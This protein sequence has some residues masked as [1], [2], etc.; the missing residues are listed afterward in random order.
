[1]R[2]LLFSLIIVS[3]LL[4]CASSPQSDESSYTHYS[5]KI[6]TYSFYK[7]VNETPKLPCGKNIAV[8][9]AK[10]S[11]FEIITDSVKPYAA[12]SAI[13]SDDYDYIVIGDVRKCKEKNG[14][15]VKMKLAVKIQNAS[16]E[17]LKNI[18]ISVK[19]NDDFSPRLHK[20]LASFFK[21][22]FEK[23]D[24]DSTSYIASNTIN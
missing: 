6:T 8:S 20:A 7:F 4:S 21:D 17:E 22:S 16:G 23:K 5:S 2:K 3:M 1:M 19:T 14:K 24:I 13:V 11:I 12:N 18:N 15:V 9:C 10:E